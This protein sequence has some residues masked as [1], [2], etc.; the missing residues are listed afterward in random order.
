[1]I[2]GALIITIGGVANLFLTEKLGVIFGLGI[3][4]VGTLFYVALRLMIQ[5]EKHLKDLGE[6]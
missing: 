4:S 5:I 3:I 1:M 6:L 2:L